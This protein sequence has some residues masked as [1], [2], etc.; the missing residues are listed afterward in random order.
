VVKLQAFQTITLL[1]NPELS[2]VQSRVLT[3]TLHR[4]LGGNVV[5]TYVKSSDQ[6]NLT[7]VFKLSRAKAVE[8]HE[9]IDAYHAQELTL[10]D[11][12]DRVWT[13]KLARNPFEYSQGA[14]NLSEITLQF[15]GTLSA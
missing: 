6:Q 5:Y 14:R 4:S 11:H 2:D 12:R 3:N 1:P 8:L 10:T 7:F 15:V 13:V 9:F